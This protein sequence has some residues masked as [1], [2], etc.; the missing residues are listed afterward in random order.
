MTID[1]RFQELAEL[2]FEQGSS[3][4][5]GSSLAVFE[6]GKPVVNLWQGETVGGKPWNA[7][8]VSV[9]FSCTKG[10]ASILAHR[11]IQEGKLDL[12]Q[13]VSY[14]WP[15]FAQAGKQNIPVKWLLQHKAGLSATRRDLT[16]DE[17]TDGH[18]LEDELAAQEPLWEPGTAHGYHALTFGT[19]IGKLVHNITGKTAGKYFAELIAEPLGVDAWIGLPKDKFANLAPLISD[20]NRQAVVAEPNTDLYWQAKAMT[21]GG[22]LN[23]LV[24]SYETG[25]NNPQ[26]VSAELPGAGG[27]SNAFGLAKIYSAAVTEMNGVRLLEDETLRAAVV[28]QSTGPLKFEPQDGTWFP[29][30]GNGFMVDVPGLKDLLGPSSFGHDG[31]GGQN[32]FGD[33]EHQVGFAYT[34]NYLLSGAD[35]QWRQQVLI[36]KLKEILN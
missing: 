1:S 24:E 12:E 36:R 3:V 9:I 26:L 19:L 29:A 23:H 6:D 27:V 7:D 16:M 8:T 31:L 32:A 5:G 10:L 18:T 2:F 13:K 15:E 34:S 35:D 25:F 28:P 20:G 30:W 17:I 21:F 33:F 11:L 14:Y 4:P 22:A